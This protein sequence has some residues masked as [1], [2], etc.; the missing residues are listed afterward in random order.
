MK[1]ASSQLLVALPL[2]MAGTGCGAPE[3]GTPVQSQTKPANP[4]AANR[5]PGRYLVA[6]IEGNRAQ[7]EKTFAAYRPESISRIREDLYLL[8]I[9]EDPGPETMS[10]IADDAD[11]IKAIQPD[12]TH[13]IN[14]PGRMPRRVD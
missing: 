4:S 12:Y 9:S 8:M 2:L 3:N 7:I 14:P 11:F 6:V 5:V 1:R 10:Q 13:S